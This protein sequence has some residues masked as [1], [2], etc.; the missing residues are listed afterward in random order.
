[1]KGYLPYHDPSHSVISITFNFTRV[2]E[3]SHISII[4]RILFLQ[5]NFH[6]KRCDL[7]SGKYGML[8]LILLC[9]STTITELVVVFQ[10]HDTN[11][12]ILLTHGIGRIPIIRWLVTR[13][14][15]VDLI[16]HLGNTVLLTHGAV[17]RLLH[18]QLGY[19]PSH[20][21]TDHYNVFLPEQ[22]MGSIIQH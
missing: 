7:Q 9:I 22:A 17:I 15:Q 20:P 8:T 5:V 6:A 14:I 12:T 21:C 2:S 16:Q 13:S 10:G 1:M 11:T 3:V 4:S 19:A 18:A